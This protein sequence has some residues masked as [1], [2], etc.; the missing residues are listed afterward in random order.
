MM[1]RRAW[2]IYLGLM[3]PLALLYHFGPSFLRVGPVF[4]LL[5]A[6]SVLAILIAVRIHKPAKR[7]PW[8]L[9]AL[10]QGLFVAG[11]V[12]AYNYQRVFH[13]ELPFPSVAARL[14]VAAGRKEPSFYL[15]M[16]SIL[17]L[18]GT[19]SV[20]GWILL[21]G[22]YQT[23]SVL[24]LGWAVFYLLWGAAALHPSMRSLEERDEG[25]QD[26]L[27]GRRRLMILAGAALMVPGV[28]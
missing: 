28:Q 12:I 8:Y 6:S 14:A 5:G 7:A 3:A 27:V 19:D 10:G 22:N 11:D 1:K 16:A 15:M 21:H 9:F 17:F 23:G 20:Y 25:H 4:N 18:F 24:D 2:L 26:T 13:A